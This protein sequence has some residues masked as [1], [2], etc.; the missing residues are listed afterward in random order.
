VQD[1]LNKNK[2]VTNL[3]KRPKTTLNLEFSQQP[4]HEKFQL[5]V[6]LKFR[7]FKNQSYNNPLQ[8]PNAHQNQTKSNKLTLIKPN[9]R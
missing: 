6:K 7:K 2:K 3:S 5:K 4:E 8:A 9:L 1:R